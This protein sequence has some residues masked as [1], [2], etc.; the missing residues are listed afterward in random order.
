MNQSEED[1][2]IQ[3]IIP[4]TTNIHQV[5]DLSSNILMTLG[6]LPSNDEIP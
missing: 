3:P 1:T 2:G 5:L 4:P 6:F